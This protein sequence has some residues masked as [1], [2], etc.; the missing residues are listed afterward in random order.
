MTT[1]GVLFLATLFV[2]V[3]LGVIIIGQQETIKEQK[4]VIKIMDD[5]HNQLNEQAHE[6]IRLTK[7]H[8]SLLIERDALR[9]TLEELK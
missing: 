1:T 2:I 7:V 3:I 8:N 4:Q 5:G 9:K 6:L